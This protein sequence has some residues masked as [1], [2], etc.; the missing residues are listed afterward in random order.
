MPKAIAEMSIDNRLLLSKLS[1]MKRGEVATYEDFSKWLGRPIANSSDLHSFST[2]RTRLRADNGIVL[3]VVP[4]I[5]YKLLD[6]LEALNND[7]R[8]SRISREAKQLKKDLATV[9][10][11][12]FNEQQK[13]SLVGKVTQAHMIEETCKEKSLKKLVSVANGQPVIALGHAFEA[14]KKNL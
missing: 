1:A 10:A 14:L 4:K 2:V 7:T 6:H 11:V 12:D 9:D 3:S 13:L 5:G 8:T